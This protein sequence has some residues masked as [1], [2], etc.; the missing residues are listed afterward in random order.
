MFGQLLLTNLNI[1]HLAAGEAALDGRADPRVGHLL[2]AEG[3][4]LALQV[5][6]SS[7]PAKQ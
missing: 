2:E 5:P 3:L 1:P 6:R 4:D 7:L